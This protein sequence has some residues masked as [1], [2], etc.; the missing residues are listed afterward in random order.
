MFTRIEQQGGKE[1]GIVEQSGTLDK[2]PR[3]HK[4]RWIARV[5][6]SVGEEETAKRE[7]VWAEERTWPR[8]TKIDSETAQLLV[9]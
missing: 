6:S 3:L 9:L 1:K 8:T 4:R 7:P 2:R 5:T